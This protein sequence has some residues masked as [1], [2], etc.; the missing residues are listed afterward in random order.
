MAEYNEMSID[1]VKLGMFI[2]F[3][4]SWLKH[5]FYTNS[6]RVT[7]HQQVEALVKAGVRKVRYYPSK[8]YVSYSES[9]TTTPEQIDSSLPQKQNIATFL[10]EALQLKQRQLEVLQKRVEGLDFEYEAVY[11]RISEVG[12]LLHSDVHAGVKATQE[13]VSDTIHDTAEEMELFANMIT[14]LPTTDRSESTHRLNVCYLCLALGSVMGLSRLQLYELGAAAILHDIGKTKI[15]WEI[16]TKRPPYT[17]EDMQYLELHPLYGVKSLADVKSITKSVLDAIYQHHER[18]DGSGYP[19]KRTALNISL[20]ARMIAVVDTYDNLCNRYLTK[21]LL[22]PHESLSYIYSRLR[23]GLSM[24]I[25][26]T[27]IK[28]IGVYPPGCFVVL[29][30]GNIAIV[31]ATNTYKS[32]LPIIIVYNEDVPREKPIIINLREVEGMTIVRS[33]LPTE[34]PDKVVSYLQQGGNSGLLLASLVGK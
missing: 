5:P 8:S 6:F 17:F 11:N 2:E 16:M 13:F 22:T 15:P 29:S 21:R 33:L 34:V 28:T 10:D 23:D 30:D 1:R 25:V 12:N 31:I 18:C 3:K 4:L 7:S 24:D 9:T 14:A 26:T 27:F 20:M 19:R 32:N